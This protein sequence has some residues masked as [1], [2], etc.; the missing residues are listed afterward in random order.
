MEKLIKFIE[1][2]IEIKFYG[3]VEIVIQAGKIVHV[4]RTESIKFDDIK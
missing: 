4:K 3:T 2:L 1:N